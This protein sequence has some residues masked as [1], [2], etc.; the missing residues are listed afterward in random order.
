M[1]KFKVSV[2]VTAKHTYEVEVEASSESEAEEIATSY[3][4]AA[5]NPPD[6]NVYLGDCEYEADA[7]Q[8]TFHCDECSQLIPEAQY[9]ALD[10]MC[11]TCHARVLQEDI[12]FWNAT[13][14]RIHESFTRVLK[15]AVAAGAQIF[16]PTTR[17]QW[18]ITT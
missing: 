3:D 4:I 11:P 8:I 16:D 10:N 6:L 9:R 18:R 2:T 5:A 12:D 13:P 17:R 1:P 15:N 14:A 7:T